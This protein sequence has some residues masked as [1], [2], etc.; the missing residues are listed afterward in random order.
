[1]NLFVISD[2]VHPVPGFGISSNPS[3]FPLS[4]STNVYQLIASNFDKRFHRQMECL[5][6]LDYDVLLTDQEQIEEEE[7]EDLLM[8]K[9][10][11]LKARL[12]RE[13]M[14][15][16]RNQRAHEEQQQAQQLQKPKKSTS[17]A[18]PVVI[19][20]ASDELTHQIDSLLDQSS[21]LSK[22]TSSASLPS[23]SSKEI[24]RKPKELTMA[25][26]PVYGRTGKLWGQAITAEEHEI[27]TKQITTARN[28]PHPPTVD[29]NASPLNSFSFT[30]PANQLELAG[31]FQNT[32]IQYNKIYRKKTK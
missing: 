3:P 7:D 22:D 17:S 32:Y 11:K 6:L 1:M 9:E 2:F 15:Q 21:T 31:T 29:P 23:N 4:A 10:T 30:P 13:K 28:V 12:E 14:H 8:E 27:S 25:P 26:E 24:T 5:N 18:P 16:Q 19:V 20:S